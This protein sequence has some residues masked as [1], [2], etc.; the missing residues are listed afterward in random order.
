VLVAFVAGRLRERPAGPRRLRLDR[1]GASIFQ[2]RCS[3]VR[4]AIRMQLMTRKAETHDVKA[5]LACLR[6]AFDPYRSHSRRDI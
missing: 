6:S 5:I 4:F 3:P 1:I 2:C